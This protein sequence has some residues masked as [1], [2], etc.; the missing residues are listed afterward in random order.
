MLVDPRPVSVED[1]DEVG[2]VV[3][4]LMPELG[5]RTPARTR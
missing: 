1:F 4:E 2:G 5:I 3:A